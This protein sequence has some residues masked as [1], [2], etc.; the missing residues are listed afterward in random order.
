ALDIA[1]EIGVS[2]TF[3]DI[4]CAAYKLVKSPAEFD[5]IAAPNLF[6]DILGDLG[7]VL[8]GS[9][10]LTYSGNFND[11]G[12]AVFQTNHGAAY[13]LVGQDLANPAG[14]ILS[15][16]FLLREHF[17]LV[18]EANLIEE[19]LVRVWNRGWRTADLMARDCRQVGTSR[20]GALV[21]EA[22]RQLSDSPDN[23]MS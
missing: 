15:L 3:L 22:V 8:V 12:A 9:R 5:V 10:G 4:D 21:L 18:R 23:G 16:A 1:R 17:G 14:Q 2:P 6:G 11:D 7:G 13:D 20:M 19:A